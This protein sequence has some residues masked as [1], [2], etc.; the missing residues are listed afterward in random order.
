M[1]LMFV[2]RLLV[3]FSLTVSLKDLSLQG[4]FRVRKILKLQKC[5][6]SVT[7]ETVLAAFVRPS[8]GV[9]VPTVLLPAA[10]GAV[11][12]FWCVEVGLPGADLQHGCLGA[13]QICLL[14]FFPPKQFFIS[15]NLSSHHKMNYRLGA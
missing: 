1:Q 3:W 10:W 9:G 13:L 6:P 7:D 2:E 11:L 5:L 12:S 8:G 15:G 14:H 4:K